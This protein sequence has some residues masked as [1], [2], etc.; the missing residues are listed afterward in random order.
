MQETCDTSRLCPGKAVAF[1]PSVP[2][3]PTMRVPAI[4]TGT[5]STHPRAPVLV[6]RTAARTDVGKVRAHNEDAVH[7][8][9][10]GHFFLVADGMG[11]HAAGEIASRMA[12]EVVR[13]HLER[14]RR[15][16]VRLGARKDADARTRIRATLERVARA[17][18]AAVYERGQRDPD[19]EG[20]GTTLEIALILSGELFVAHVGDSRTYLVR[21]G[22]ATQ[23][24]RDHTI[25]QM[26]VDHGQCT[27]DQLRKSARRTLFNAIG[28]NADLRIDHVQRELAPGDRVVVCTDGLHDYFSDEELSRRV[29]RQPP[30]PALGELVELARARGGHDN[31]TGVVIEATAV[32]RPASHPADDAP[33]PMPALGADEWDDEPT[34]PRLIR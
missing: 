13:D 8:D 16:L 26:M 12:I 23:L 21:A 9:P 19:K 22:V 28:A 15:Y 27:A 2:R 4:G 20:M 18:Q 33:T 17:A 7:V 31:I 1:T 25:G 5:H 32:P 11:G 34:V 14:E 3:D 30:G 6:L 10:S 24:T 29:G